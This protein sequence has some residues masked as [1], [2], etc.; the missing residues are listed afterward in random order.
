MSYHVSVDSR[1]GK[2]ID[3]HGTEF[4]PVGNMLQPHEGA[5]FNR[6][7]LGTSYRY[8]AGAWV[9]EG[10]GP[11]ALTIEEADGVPQVA[12]VD[13]LQ[14]DQADSFVLTDL[15]GGDA[16]VDMIDA[17]AGQHGLLPVLSGDPA[18]YLDG[19]GSWSTP[20]AAPAPDQD[21]R[22]LALMGL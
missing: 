11:S 2:W 19:S 8:T 14:F 21:A 3:G 13:K 20:S 17:T 18:E 22:I 4:P 5:I 1:D 12:A 9:A 6:L 10:G 15:G 7:D 16:R